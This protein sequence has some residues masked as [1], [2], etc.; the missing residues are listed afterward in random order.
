M[1]TF[2]KDELH[3]ILIFISHGNITPQNEVKSE[4]GYEKAEKFYKKIRKISRDIGF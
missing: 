1:A 2:T 4:F 3:M